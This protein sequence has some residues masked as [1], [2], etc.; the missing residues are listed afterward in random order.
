MNEYEVM[1]EVK[2]IRKIYGECKKKL[3]KATS[4][5]RFLTE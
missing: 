5:S 4:Q 2:D 1:E 3:S